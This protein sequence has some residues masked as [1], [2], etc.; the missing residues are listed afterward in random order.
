M[1]DQ[2]AHLWASA[3]ILE[4]SVESGSCEIL[5]CV[6]PLQDRTKCVSAF[7]AQSGARHFPSKFLHEVALVKS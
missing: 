6:S 4:I 1:L 3:F 5:T 2:G 7:R